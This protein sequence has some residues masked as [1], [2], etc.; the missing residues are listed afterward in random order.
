MAVTTGGVILVLGS[1]LAGRSEPAVDQG[2]ER[3]G[4]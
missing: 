1:L 4:P 3:A 2:D